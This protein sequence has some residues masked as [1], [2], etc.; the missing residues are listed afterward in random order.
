MKHGL[1]LTVALFTDFVLAE[2]APSSKAGATMDNSFLVEEAYNQEKGVVQHIL[3]V[4]WEADRVPGPDERAWTMTFTQEWPVSSQRHQ[5]SYTVPYS[6]LDTGGQS[7]D[8]VEDILLNYR[9]QA[10]FESDKVPAFAPRFS[11]VLPT[12]DADKGFGNDTIGYQFNLPF[13][14]AVSESWTVHLNTG[15]TFLT[16]VD[17]GLGGGGRSP[18]RDPVNFRLGASAI[19]AIARDCNLMLEF[20]GNWDE[21]F[22]EAGKL[23]RKFAPVVSPG[24]RYAFNFSSGAQMVLG[25]AVPLGLASEAPDYGIFIYASFEHTFLRSK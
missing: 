13:S 8:G 17:V 5:F 19:Y 20:V 11:L 18:R 3:N 6:F 4:A 7:E 24:A 23:D 21:E 15:V 12:G 22:D 10:L 9:V 16:D 2:E 1:L 25:L 14:K